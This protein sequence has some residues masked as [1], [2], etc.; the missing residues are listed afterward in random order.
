MKHCIFL[1]ILF[2]FACRSSTEIDIEGKSYKVYSPPNT[3]KVAD[4]FYADESEVSNIEY[5]SYLYWLA[6]IY[7]KESKKYL[8]ALPDTLVWSAELSYGEPYMGNYFSHPAY[9]DFPIIGVNLSQAKKFTD[10]RTERVVENLLVKKGLIKKNED[11]D[12]TN[13]FSINRYL[14][15]DYDWIIKRESLALPIYKIP[16]IEEWEK[17]AG[18]DTKFQYGIDSLSNYNKK[19]SKRYKCLFNTNDYPAS[20]KEMKYPSILRHRSNPVTSFAKNIYGLYGTI[21]NVAELVDHQN[22]IKGGSWKQKIED[23][24]I[25]KNEL[26]EKPN[27]WVGFRN[28][29]TFEL[30]DIKTY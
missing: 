24:E 25:S 10:W 21:G 5:K 8:Q 20:D 28:V 27:G 14:E 26:F 23:I 30:R 29:C 15:G 1:S 12:S 2:V 17:M 13:Y 11:K 9:D 22:T 6:G 16:T 19:I 18:M 7:G 3:I 4:N